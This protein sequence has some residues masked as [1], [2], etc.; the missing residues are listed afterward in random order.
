M[1]P[2]TTAFLDKGLTRIQ[3][4][5]SLFIVDMDHA[6]FVSIHPTLAFSF[7]P[8]QFCFPAMDD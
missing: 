8:L 7:V 1:E 4:Y 6:C 5:A 3:G 2:Q